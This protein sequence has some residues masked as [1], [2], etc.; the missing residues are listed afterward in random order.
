MTDKVAKIKL[1]FIQDIVV[2]EKLMDPYK[3]N[4]TKSLA[5]KHIRERDSSKI[6][7]FSIHSISK[8]CN[9]NRPFA[10][11]GHMS[12]YLLFAMGLGRKRCGAKGFRG[13]L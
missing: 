12:V 13:P 10:G 5:I 11:F 2:Q 8:L 3:D 1:C 9:V 7:R 6:P 4:I